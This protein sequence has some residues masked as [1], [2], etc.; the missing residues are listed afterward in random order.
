LVDTIVK[1]AAVD[2]IVGCC[3]WA[4]AHGALPTAMRKIAPMPIP[5]RF[6]LLLL[7]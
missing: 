3:P 2:V 7:V 4:N 5:S 1:L 6:I